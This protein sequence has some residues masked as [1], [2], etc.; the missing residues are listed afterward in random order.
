[1]KESND[2]LQLTLDLRCETKSFTD[3]ETK[4]TREYNSYYVDVHGVRVYLAPRDTTGRNILN[5]Y[6]EGKF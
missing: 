3:K 4:E 2:V 6:F 1:M 5:S